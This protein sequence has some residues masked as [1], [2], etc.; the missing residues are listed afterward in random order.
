MPS[1][2]VYTD[3]W[4]GRFAKLLPASPGKSNLPQPLWKSNDKQASSWRHT[5]FHTGQNRYFTWWL[6]PPDSCR[7]L[8]SW[9]QLS[10]LHLFLAFFH[11]NVFPLRLTRFCIARIFEDAFTMQNWLDKI[12]A[13]SKHCCCRDQAPLRKMCKI[14]TRA[15]D[16]SAGNRTRVISMATMYSTTRPLMLEDIVGHFWQRIDKPGDSV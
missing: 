13:C 1:C 4:H 11:P 16:A 2:F 7:N 12:S 9:F 14:G 6:C 8:N 3:L 15:K 10:S 5:S